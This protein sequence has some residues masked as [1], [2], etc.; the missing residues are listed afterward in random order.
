MPNFAGLVQAIGQYGRLTKDSFRFRADL[1]NWKVFGEKAT[2]P[3]IQGFS[4]EDV[5]IDLRSAFLYPP[6]EQ[7]FKRV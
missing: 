3:K 6:V 1:F 2:P 4:V 5:I 7:A